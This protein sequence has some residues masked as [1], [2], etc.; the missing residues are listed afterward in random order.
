M[1]VKAWV[2]SCTGIRPAYVKLLKAG[3]D[4][5]S[6]YVHHYGTEQ[7][8]EE[9]A[10]WLSGVF[11]THKGTVCV[12]SLDERPLVKQRT[13]PVSWLKKGL[14]GGHWLGLLL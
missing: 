11:L 5:R 1:D 2:F 7:E 14:A 9:M 8:L 6:C 4:M 13:E 12:V 10:V 3:M